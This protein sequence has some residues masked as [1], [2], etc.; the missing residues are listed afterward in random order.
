MKKILILSAN[1]TNTNQLRLDEEVREIEAGL[2]RSRSRDRFQ[3]ICKWAV[4]SNDLRRALL[5]HKP[6]I[7]HF[8]GHGAGSQGLALENNSGQ[9]QLVKTE[10]LAGLFELFDS[11][12]CVLL[13]ACY[14]EAQAQAIYQ[15]VDYVIGMNRA[16]G[17]RAAIEFAVGFYD[18]LGADRSY[19]DAYKFGCLNIDLEGIPESSTPVLKSKNNQKITP[20]QQPNQDSKVQNSPSNR[21][22]VR[23]PK[24]KPE[25]IIYKSAS[26]LEQPD[27]QI[28]LDSAYYIDRPPIETDCYEA[29][30]KSGALIRVKAPRQMGKSSL[31]TRILDHASKQSYKTAFVNFQSVDG[32]LLGDLDLFLQWFAASITDALSLPEKL[33]EHWK[34]VLGSK[35]KCT[36]YFQRY[37]LPSIDT[38]VALGLDEVDEVFKHPAIANDFF[39]LLRAWHER[40]KNDPVWK[41]LRLIIVHSQEVYIPLNINQSP[42]NVGLPIE[43]PDLSQAQV[44]ELTQ[45]HGLNWTGEQVEQLMTLVGGHPYL[46]RVALYQIARGRMTLEKLQQIAPTEEGPYSDHL[47]RHLLNLQENAQLLAAFKEVLSVDCPVDVGT[48]EAFKLRSMGLVKFQGNEVMPLCELYCEYFGDRLGIKN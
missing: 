42:F 27:G 40:A 2:E 20:Q 36:N 32:E 25:E 35:N 48:A 41:K 13:N 10:T 17:D 45:R 16:I 18:A 24:P 1:P 5:D 9:M 19:E 30:V 23:V 47:R 38:P 22:A 21:E 7:V 44:Q 8:S 11:I 31:M 33:E 29:I 34:G 6:E 43:L 3:I 26:P 15:H 46:T 12:E 39:G 37:L 28:P 4:R 14:S